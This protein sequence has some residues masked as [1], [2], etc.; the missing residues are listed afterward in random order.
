MNRKHTV[1]DYQKIINQLKEVNPKIEFT[2]DFII[3]YPG[4]TEED[5]NLSL[6]ILKDV[7]FI[8]TY[9]YIYSPRYGTP[10]AKL[11]LIDK[12]IAKNRL[13]EF[14][15]ISEKIK[16][17]HKKK[18]LNKIIKV[19]FENRVNDNQF[20]GR[21]EFQNS[22]IVNC[23]DNIE[24]KIMSVKIN[25]FNLNTLVGDLVDSKNLAA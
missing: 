18:S 6:K 8:N 4:E 24:G 15:N 1:E 16:K 25:D 10:A 19:L 12:Q 9:S 14:Q 13:I 23:K 3:A 11:N 2:S 7:K 17:E 21:D 5:F 20:F 22:I